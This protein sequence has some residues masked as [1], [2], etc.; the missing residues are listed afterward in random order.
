[1]SG[2]NC[3][4]QNAF[5]LCIFQCFKLK[6]VLTHSVLQYSTNC[7]TFWAKLWRIILSTLF[8]GTQ[9]TARAV[10][11]WKVCFFANSGV[12]DRVIHGVIETQD[13]RDVYG[14]WTGYKRDI[15]G[16]YTGY[17][18]DRNGIQYWSL[19]SVELSYIESLWNQLLGGR[20]NKLSIR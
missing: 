1:M 3:A 19:L 20:I 6:I 10:S 9:D 5:S 7:A 4:A 15:N 18:R 11:G 2:K 17:V 14:I 12:Q 8:P 13:V 16:I